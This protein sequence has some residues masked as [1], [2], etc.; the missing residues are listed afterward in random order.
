MAALTFTQLLNYVVLSLRYR[1]KHALAGFVQ[2][3]MLSRVEYFNYLLAGVTYEQTALLQKI[4]NRS[5]RL[6]FRKK[7]QNKSR[8]KKNFMAMSHI[9]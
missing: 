1:N 8:K 9:S 3:R 2:S 5:A 6:I 4:Q 7:K